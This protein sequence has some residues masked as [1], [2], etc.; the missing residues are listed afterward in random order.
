[1]RQ[2]PPPSHFA[3]SASLSPP[4]SLLLAED[5]Q[6]FI[7]QSQPESCD[8]EFAE[9]QPESSDYE[10]AQPDSCVYE[11]AQPES[12]NSEFCLELNAVEDNYSLATSGE[13]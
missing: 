3:R 13:T 2:L 4:P 7:T 9:S 11:F 8:Y 5:Y 12:C 1:M 6:E 10:F